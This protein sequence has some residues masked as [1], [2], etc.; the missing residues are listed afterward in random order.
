MNIPRRKTDGPGWWKVGE[1]VLF[2][3]S[4]GHVSTIFQPVVSVRDGA[5]SHTIAET[6]SVSPSVV[7]PYVGCGFHQ[8]VTL[9]R[10]EP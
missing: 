2:R 3:C 10:W 5:P 4:N 6:G 1:Y 8:F 7:C 9:D